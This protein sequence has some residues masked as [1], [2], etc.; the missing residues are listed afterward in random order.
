[1][2]C[3]LPDGSKDRRVEDDEERRLDHARCVTI[4]SSPCL[5]QAP[6]AFLHPGLF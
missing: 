6:A 4:S 5:T 1:M 2:L 3:E